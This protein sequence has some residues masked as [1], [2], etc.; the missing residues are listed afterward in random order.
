L[1]PKDSTLPPAPHPLDPEL[2]ALAA[3][4]DTSAREALV[5]RLERRVRGI[6]LAILGHAADAEDA[7]QAILLELLGSLK[8]YRGG[9][10]LAWC[11]RIAVRT[12]M[13]QARQRRVREARH[14]FEIDLEAVPLE[15]HAAREHGVPR[16]ILDYLAELPET[17]RVALVL[18][19]VMDYS[20]EEI[21][22]LTGVS[23][24]TVKDRLLHAREQVRRNIRREIALVP[25]R[26]GG[27]A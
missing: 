21:A 6:A 18:R 5:S 13:R 4:G 2:V 11:D 10:L 24:N 9:H 27:A 16:P 17:R 23:P 14:D 1:E 12:A 20:I 7:T 3:A 15:R 8:G 19:H 25:R 22:E 26:P